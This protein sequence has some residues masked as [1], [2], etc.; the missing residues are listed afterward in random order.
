MCGNGVPD[1]LIGALK[2]KSSGD[3]TVVK[4]G[5]STP[6]TS[7]KYTITYDLNGGSWKN[8]PD[9]S[10]YSYYYKANDATPYYK[11]G[12]D[13]PFD[14]LNSNLERDNYGFIGWTCDKD[15]SQTPTQYLDIMT[16]WQSNITLT[17][18]WQPKQQ[19][20]FYYLNRRNNFLVILQHLKLSRVT[21]Y[22]FT[23]NVESDDFTLPTPTKPGYDLSVG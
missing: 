10:I 17:A 18:H 15:S 2:E 23:F 9:E 20:V 5:E 1:R 4:E 21:V 3:G 11:I 6:S 7:T 16:N 8:T 13:K 19:Y 12:F 14:T 22:I